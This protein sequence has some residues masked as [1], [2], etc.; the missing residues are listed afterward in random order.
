MVLTQTL[1]T[2]LFL[3]PVAYLIDNGDIFIVF[4]V[5]LVTGVYFDQAGQITT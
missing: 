3:F 2:H 5:V 1:P 4:Y